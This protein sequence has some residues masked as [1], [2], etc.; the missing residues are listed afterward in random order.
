MRLQAGLLGALG[1]LEPTMAPAMAQDAD[2]SG[3]VIIVDDYTWYSRIYVFGDRVP[4]MP[5]S[6]SAI[7][8]GEAE[9]T[10]ADRPADLLNRV[11]GVNLQM[12]SGQE[13]LIAIR[14]P[15]LNG[16]AGQGSFLIMVNGVP[17]RASAFGNVNAA[18]ELPL[19]Q[20]ATIEI[21]RGP[22]SARYGSNAEHGLINALLPEPG[23][24]TTALSLS[25]SSLSRF[26]LRATATRYSQGDG[27]AP[28]VGL[29]LQRDLGWRESS[30]SDLGR[31]SATAS[32]GGGD[33]SGFAF[34]TA[35]FLD[36]DTAG[37]ITGE[38]AYRDEALARTNP[39]ADAFRQSRWGMVAAHLTR[40]T[41]A[42]VSWRITPY[43]R[44]QAME[45]SQHFLPYD[46]LESN[47]H[48][49]AGLM[50]RVR[51][52]PVGAFEWSLGADLDL[53]SGWLKET[54][55]RA[56]F[57]PFPQ[58]THY[59]F[60]VATQTLALWGEADMRPTE[61]LR[62]VAGLR[63]EWQRYDYSTDAA[64]GING[65]FLV[66]PDREDTFAF[67]APKLGLVWNTLLLNEDAEVYANA[68]RGA[69]APQASDL[70]RLQ[71]LQMAPSAKVETLDSLEIGLR[72]R[73]SA[74]DL[75][76]DLAAYWMEK[77]G[78]FFR[79]ADGLNVTDGRTRHRGLE[80]GLDWQAL[81]ALEL[82]ANLAWSHQSYA[83]DRIV[84]NA[85]EAIRSGNRIDTAP[86][87]LWNVSA[88]WAPDG[89]W[90][91]GLTVEHVGAYFTDAANTRTYPGHTL[92]HAFI[93]YAL[94]EDL[95]VSLRL[96]NLFDIAHADRADFAFG[97]DRYFPGE[98]M[99]VTLTLTKR[100]D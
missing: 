72:G 1:A 24:D 53:A 57:G 7:L 35:G 60:T 27:Y 49:S 21:V 14:S 3:E 10:G 41:D 23:R 20:A 58:G 44:A 80:A 77:R 73:L 61:A 32:F 79:D 97:E 76:Y 29:S 67:L 99:N 50:L 17:M 89:P 71:S 42:G 87:W 5:G 33:W 83:F 75:Y 12:N 51:P 63:A 40:R 95:E 16:G 8:K 25:G 45:F 37:Y 48:G 55:A 2:G 91:G 22:G 26:G 59:D 34:A 98:P 70:Y 66:V 56:G 13:S 6:Q 47:G 94:A 15:V 38:Q 18:M 82:T 86:E 30:G 19:D 92:T 74:I 31:L 68:A 69:R 96:R 62:V 36:Q 54:Q 100:F 78:F 39:N 81:S 28:W 4:G 84:G 52:D 90:R 64:A 46:G 11:A 43:L 88:V 65:R 9:A 93:A 85:S